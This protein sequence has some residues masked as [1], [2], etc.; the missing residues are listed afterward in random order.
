[1]SIIPVGQGTLV[2][3][4]TNP[5]TGQLGQSSGSS[6]NRFW[7]KLRGP[8]KTT[9]RRKRGSSD[10]TP[11]VPPPALPV[12]RPTPTPT[13]KTTP[14]PSSDNVFVSYNYTTEEMTL[15]EFAQRYQSNLP[16]QVVVTHGVYWRDNMEVNISSSERLNIH[17]IRHRESVSQPLHLCRTIDKLSFLSLFWSGGSSV[18]EVGVQLVHASP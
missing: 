5:N 17:F 8:P 7:S 3:M 9:P 15:S 2:V 10:S 11:V 14:T 1:M 18:L 13:K 6:K 16:Q 4:A 12:S